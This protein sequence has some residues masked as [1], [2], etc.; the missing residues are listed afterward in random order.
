MV[1]IRLGFPVSLGLG[2]LAR[3]KKS[4]RFIMDK[5][6]IKELMY[7]GLKEI[8]N[9]GRYY[10]RSSVGKTYSSFTSTGKDV[11]HQFIEDMAGYICEAEDA[12]LDERAKEIV[13]KELKKS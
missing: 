8:M 5:Q 3:V 6:A 1:L 7:G 11:M 13:L 10:Y 9:N 2:D 12:E 4:K